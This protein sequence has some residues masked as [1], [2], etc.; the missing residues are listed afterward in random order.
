MKSNSSRPSLL[1][2][3]IAGLA[4]LSFAAPAGANSRYQRDQAA[5]QVLVRFHNIPAGVS[6]TFE[7]TNLRATNLTVG[8][9]DTVLHVL[10]TNWAQ[11]AANDDCGGELRSCVTLAASGV[12]RTVIV[13]VRAYSNTSFGLATYR[14]TIGGSVVSGDTNFG[15]TQVDAGSMPSGTWIETVQQS[16]G[17]QFPSSQLGSTDTV[18]IVLGGS[19]TNLIAADDD[20]G[21]TTMSRITTPIACS[22]CT[23]VVGDFAGT[24]LT[25]T[26]YTTVVWST[27]H[28]DSDLDR[29]PD[30]LETFQ[31]GTSPSNRDSDGDGIPDGVEVLGLDDPTLRFP[32][33]GALAW[34]KDLFLEVDYL[35]GGGR[36]T[37]A[38]AED[39]ARGYRIN[40]FKDN[41][42]GG[43][44]T[45]E[46]LN[47]ASYTDSRDIRVHLDIGVANNNASENTRVWGDWF[48]SNSVTSDADCSGLTPLRNSNPYWHHLVSGSG[49]NS[50]F[51]RCGRGNPGLYAGAHELGHE[52]GLE[53]G[54][55]PVGGPNGSVMYPS[56]MNYQFARVGQD[57]AFSAKRWGISLNPSG[58][59]EQS[60]GG[61][62]TKKIDYINTA[63]TAARYFNNSNQ[64]DFDTG[65]SFDTGTVPGQGTF[66]RDTGTAFSNKWS[67]TGLIKDTEIAW[68]PGSPATM[69]LFH[70][71]TSGATSR[72]EYRTTTSTALAACNNKQT[73]FWAN[74]VS[75]SSP[76]QLASTAGAKRFFGVERIKANNVWKLLVVF[77][78][79][80]DKLRYLTMDASGA[81]AVAD[82]AFGT[83][84]VT[85]PGL[86]RVSD[87]RV[88]VFAGV[89]SPAQ[90]RGWEYDG[91]GNFWP[92]ARI[93]QL[94][95]DGSPVMVG[96]S[97]VALTRGYMT[98]TSTT[99]QLVGALADNTNLIHMAR[100]DYG[101]ARWTQLAGLNASIPGGYWSDNK[102]GV[103]YVP[104]LNSW[105]FTG[106]YYL[107]YNRPNGRRNTFLVHTAGNN[108]GAV[109][110]P[111]T[112]LEP[113][114]LKWRRSQEEYLSFEWDDNI[115]DG[116]QDLV[117]DLDYGD[118]HL[119]A[120][121]LLGPS[122]PNLL[123]FSPIADGHYN[124]DLID[125]DDWSVMVGNL[126]CSL[127]ACSR[128]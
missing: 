107:M 52:L 94:Y 65:N 14:S 53:H 88:L 30:E 127:G 82:V 16:R 38:D 90:L 18:L 111:A 57:P 64:V 84:V 63:F 95:N 78:D 39:L 100:Y 115:A 80:T 4:S 68:L 27:D 10:D 85:G 125:Q 41:G 98:D 69:Y 73:N 26:G 46:Q 59:A 101:T 51:G 19:P 102:L 121:W 61:M 33:F 66:G 117:Y 89:G 2:A 34:I 35:N 29:L 50:G 21:V 124:L 91:N 104:F 13:L 17:I 119:R 74:C 11:L 42:A 123:V 118:N 56:I 12:A 103:A 3:L 31:I 40:G 32:Y 113:S 9:P 122:S 87:S 71:Y 24:A 114:A 116:G 1:A 108:P 70:L 54:G 55:W 15:G 23:V 58:V 112:G 5:G 25:G 128:R 96:N 105:P 7:T 6:A 110:D 47:S 72:I 45:F 86:V 60:W 37:G 99:V 97:G 22:T 120:A 126:P 76:T 48:G 106:R 20:S 28:T 62:G 77:V 49:N 44:L 92:T 83:S 67:T 36:W 43:L 79:A 93:A 75:F 109:V 81:S 8:A